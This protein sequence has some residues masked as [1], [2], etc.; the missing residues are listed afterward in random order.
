L[1]IHNLFIN[2]SLAEFEFF[3][4]LGKRISITGSG[5]Y[6]KVHKVKRKSDG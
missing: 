2:M 4:E 6:S 5:A 1:K 3:N